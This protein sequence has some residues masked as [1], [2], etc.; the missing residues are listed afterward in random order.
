MGERSRRGKSR[1]MNRGLM[2]MENGGG[3]ECGGY[4]AGE[5][6]DERA[7]TTVTE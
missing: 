1:N 7:R 6:N 2:G 3:F 4:G 5:S